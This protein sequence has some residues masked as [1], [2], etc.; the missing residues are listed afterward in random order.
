MTHIGVVGAGR[1]GA[2]LSAAL[3]SAGHDVVAAAGDSAASL[4][5]IETL[6]PGVRHAKPTDV[7]RAC[8]LLLLTVPD[9]ML[10]NVVTQL[11][12][13]GAIRE[14]QV[15]CHTSGRHGLAVLAS[16]TEIGARPI[17]MHPAMT[18][19]GT[20]RRPRPAHRLRV[21]HDRRRRRAG[22]RRGPR[23][24][25]ARH[26]AVGAREQAHALP[27][28]SRPRRQPPRHPGQPGDG[29][30]R[31]LRRRG[32]RRDP[33][34][35]AHRRPRQRARAGRRRADRPD[36]ARRR[37]DGPGPPRTT[38]PRTRR[39]PS[40]RTS[41]WRRPPPT[42]P[43]STDDCCRSGPPASSAC[44]TRRSSVSARP[45]PSP[46]PV[47]PPGATCDDHLAPPREHS[48][49]AGGRSA[50]RAWRDRWGFVPTMGALHAGH[51]SPDGAGA[52]GGRLRRRPSW[53]RSSSTRCSSAPG[54]DLD[55]YPRTFDADL[56][57]CAE[58]GVDVVFAPSVDEVYPGGDPQVTVDPGPLAT[59]LEGATRP[60]P[61]PRRADRRRQAV[62]AG[63]ARRGGVRGEGLPAAGADPP[64]GLRP[65]HGRRRRR[66][67]HRARGRR[68]GAVQPQPLPRRRAAPRAQ[69]ALSRALFAG[70]R[71]RVA[72]RRR[73]PRRG[74]RAS[75]GT[76]TA[77]TST[78]SS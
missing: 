2:V 47:V 77:S 68:P 29:A 39:P 61:L 41:P 18:F 69:L 28:R 59:V 33:A 13:A 73:R 4:H 16:A 25:P 3:R 74:P 19:T 7:A 11:V 14:G 66:R 44:S 27:R 50:R 8:D 43:S 51:A 24:R 75:S 67:R 5:R 26:P 38:S 6:L 58:Q 65:V 76:P 23:R 9:D 49:G 40:R 10:E 30:A 57:L 21:R 63:A 54:E 55:R 52:Q 1:V 70:P 45:V 22:V 62:R 48:R 78:T 71:R 42:G 56:A 15:V 31:R 32:P 46:A 36:R 12:G 37:E 20:E 72:R 34:S 60:T 35:A 64:D 53:S 17:A